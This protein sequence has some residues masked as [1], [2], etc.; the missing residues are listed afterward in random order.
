VPE[1]LSE[2]LIRFLH[3]L[4]PEDRDHALSVLSGCQTI[5]LESGVPRFTNGFPTEALLLV[6]SGF[7]ILRA[8][9]SPVLR[10]VVTCE[11]GPGSVLLA[12]ARTEMLVG[13]GRSS[14]T[15]IDTGAR[16]ALVRFPAVADRLVQQLALALRQN[17]EAIA[18]FAP[19]RHIDRVRGKLLELAGTYGRVVRDGVRIDFP[20]SHGLLAEMIGSSR[21]TVTRAVA[22]LQRAGFVDRRGSTYRLLV[23]PQS[24]LAK[25]RPRGSTTA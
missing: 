8:T 1:E 2:G 19:A 9:M 24:V 14:L 15:V 5:E 16:A 11:A 22:H 17:Q 21:E 13:L 3:D 7:V 12:P 25:L 4:S 20:V 6:D 23:S 18:N 10:S